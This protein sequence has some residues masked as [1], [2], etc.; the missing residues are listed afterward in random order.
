VFLH[1]AIRLT[2]ARSSTHLLQVRRQ[3]IFNVQLLRFL[4]AAA[5]LLTHT[6]SLLLPATS[7]IWAVPWTGG[8]DVF[9]VISGFIMTWMTAGQFGS[10]GAA[11]QFLRRRIIR[12]VPPYWFFTFAVIAIVIVAGGRV[13]NTTADPVQ[14]L[15]SLLFVPWPRIDGNLNPILSQGWT[16]NYEMFFYLAFA[17]SM[18]FRRGLLLLV[19][20]FC[21]LVAMHA[22]IPSSW[23]VLAFY[24]DPI[25]LE[26]VAGIALARVY[27]TGRRVPPLTSLLM[28]A[29]AVLWFA[30][31]PI[32]AGD[33]SEPISVGIP[34]ALLTSA[35]VLAPEPLRLGPIR[36]AFRAGG[37]ASYTLYL[38]HTLTAG[39]VIMLCAWIGLG[40]PWAV[41]G[42][43]SACAIIF[44]VL[45]YEI[46]E[47][48]FTAF[49]GRRFHA[50]VSE[51][52]ATVAP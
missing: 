17:L 18:M 10:D 35:L 49:L 26:F 21:L 42:I 38:S 46:L 47:A 33:F 30:L 6:A 14:V 1:I 27:L 16:L 50:R 7:P 13:R 28:I 52:P 51:G 36:R 4:A 34:A 23:F 11:A 2:G 19:I 20:A 45:F 3:V 43:A 44:A 39:A 40:S 25:I 22:F 15:T 32:D 29:A 5:I 31:V 24:S 37:D 41:I 12:I 8:V 9:F 48:P